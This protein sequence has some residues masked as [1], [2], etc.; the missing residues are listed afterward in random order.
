MT[1]DRIRCASGARIEAAIPQ[2]TRQRQTNRDQDTA[3]KTSTTSPTTAPEGSNT[4]RAGAPHLSEAGGRNPQDSLLGLG[5]QVQ[6]G[7]RRRT[8]A[9]RRPLTAS[10]P[11]SLP[12][13]A[14]PEAWRYR[15][16]KAWR[17]L[18]GESPC[19]VR[20]S[21]PPVSSLASIAESWS[22]RRTRWAKRRRGLS[23]SGAE[24]RAKLSSFVDGSRVLHMLSGIRKMNTMTCINV[25]CCS[26]S[27]L[28]GD[29]GAGSAS[30]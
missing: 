19:R 2:K 30:R 28:G 9:C 1:P 11:A 25:V 3:E 12:L 21:H 24:T 26:Q 14:A 15:A 8:I 10:A 17:I 6:W 29:F 16:K 23:S 7:L 20:A 5:N 4:P 22:T 27:C 18:Q 13:P